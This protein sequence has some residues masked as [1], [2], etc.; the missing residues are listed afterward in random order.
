MVLYCHMQ[1]EIDSHTQ[2]DRKRE[3]DEKYISDTRGS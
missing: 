2:I 1:M 3:L